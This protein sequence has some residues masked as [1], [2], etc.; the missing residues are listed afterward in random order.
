M[1]Q[2]KILCVNKNLSIFTF[3]A[4]NSLVSPDNCFIDQSVDDISEWDEE[5][6]Q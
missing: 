4:A 2:G 1:I 5:D 6:V 3:N